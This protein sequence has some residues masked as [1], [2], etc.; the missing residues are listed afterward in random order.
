MAQHD[1]ILDDAAG[2]AFLAD[3]NLAIQAIAGV[4][5]GATAPATM[6]AYQLWA[7]T[8]SGLLKQRNAA[9]TLWLVRDTLAETFVIARSSNTILAGGDYGRTFSATSTFTQTLTAAATLGDGWHCH[10]RNDGTGVIT[11]DPNSSETM[12]GSTTLLLYRG[13]SCTIVCDGTNF[14][15][16]GRTRRPGIL[17]IS[18]SDLTVSANVT[19]YIGTANANGTE[20]VLAVAM[21]FKCVMRNL[22]MNASAVPG[23]GQTF[24]YTARNTAV[25]TGITCTTSGAS[26]S[27]SNDVTHEAVFAKGDVFAIKIATSAGAAVCT[28][29]G[30]IEVEEIP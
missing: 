23:V 30:A 19:A 15:T 6:Y 13:E 22:Y 16:I 5:S 21:P 20:S 11:L 2:A 26:S 17:P 8:T 29:W 28:H 27:G 18:S 1:F 3:V 24:I 9:N 12:D 4:S 14:K 25:D 7:D 10:Y